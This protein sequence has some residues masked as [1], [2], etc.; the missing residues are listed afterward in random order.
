MFRLREK[1][2]PETGF[3]PGRPYADV[4]RGAAIRFRQKPKLALS[5]LKDFNSKMEKS[6]RP[7]VVR[8]PS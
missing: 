3:F 4:R 8:L 2:G 7:E 5:A 1:F 6:R